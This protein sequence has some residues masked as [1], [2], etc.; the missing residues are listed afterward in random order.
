MCKELKE[1]PEEINICAP[2]SK[3]AWLTE[4]DGVANGV[5]ALLDS[6]K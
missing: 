6:F 2:C 5:G 3:K 4:L 1:I